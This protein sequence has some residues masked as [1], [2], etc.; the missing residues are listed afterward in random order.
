[1]QPTA[2]LCSN[3]LS[4]SRFDKNRLKLHHCIE[5]ALCTGVVVTSAGFFVCVIISLKNNRCV[6]ARM[7]LAGLPFAWGSPRGPDAAGQTVHVDYTKFTNNS[8][9]LNSGKPVR[10][11]THTHIRWAHR[12]R[13]V[14]FNSLGSSDLLRGQAS[15]KNRSARKRWWRSEEFGRTRR[16]PIRSRGGRSLARTLNCHLRTL[17]NRFLPVRI[18]LRLHVQRGWQCLSSKFLQ[19]HPENL[20]F[21]FLP[22]D[23]SNHCPLRR[24]EQKLGTILAVSPKLCNISSLTEWQWKLF[25]TPDWLY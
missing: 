7:F 12:T 2:F 23:L 10:T 9:R 18:S 4:S 21:S 25:S 19:I 15:P 8:F 20:L 13:Q 16:R 17:I 1:M 6:Q 22:H 14:E 3:L 24:K 5:R 11:H